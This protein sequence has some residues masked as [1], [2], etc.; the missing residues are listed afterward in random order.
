MIPLVKFKGARRFLG[1]ASTSG[2]ATRNGPL[3]THFRNWLLPEEERAL[4][5]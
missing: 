5:G 3:L 1:A 2:W 4:T